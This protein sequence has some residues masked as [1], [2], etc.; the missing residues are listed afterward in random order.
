MSKTVIL[1]ETPVKFALQYWDY[2]ASPDTFG[3]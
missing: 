3:L 1:G 2:V